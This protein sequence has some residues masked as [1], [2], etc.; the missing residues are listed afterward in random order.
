MIGKNR[1]QY[2]FDGM[3]YMFNGM[4]YMM[5]C[6]I[7]LMEFNSCLIECST[8]AE[9]SSKYMLARAA[10]F[11]VYALLVQITPL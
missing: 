10:L 6:S 1:T 7:C 3:Q 2:M 8:V 9:L 11:L 4:Q 5:G